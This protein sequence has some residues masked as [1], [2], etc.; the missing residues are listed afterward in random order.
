MTDKQTIAI[1][2]AILYKR[3]DQD[4]RSIRDRRSPE[5]IEQ[6]HMK[7]AVDEA[8]RLYAVVQETN[9]AG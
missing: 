8:C 2:A 5:E 4:M 6:D 1:M 9:H 7:T 3:E